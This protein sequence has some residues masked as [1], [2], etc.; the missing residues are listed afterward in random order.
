[1]PTIAVRDYNTNPP[2]NGDYLKNAPPDS[3]K[4]TLEPVAGAPVGGAQQQVWNK[5]Q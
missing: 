2:R 5:E 3:S 1:M 4:Y